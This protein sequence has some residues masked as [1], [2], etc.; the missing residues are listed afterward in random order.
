MLLHGAKDTDVPY[1]QSAL[2]AE[3]LKRQRVPHE[4][5]TLEGF[6]HAFEWLRTDSPEVDKTYEKA[7]GF[8]QKHLADQ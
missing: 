6:P 3:Q 8:L 7:V 5:V 4:L 2:M 1:E